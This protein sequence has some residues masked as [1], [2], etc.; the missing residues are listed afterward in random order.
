MNAVA[1]IE[2]PSSTILAAQRAAFAAEGIASGPVRRDRIERLIDLLAINADALVDA[3]SADFGCRSKSQSLFSDILGIM[4]SL[5]SDRGNLAKWM[6]PRRVSA[7]P[8][9]LTGSRA[10][11]EWTPRGVIG[12][13]SPWNFPVGLAFQPLSQAFAAG[14]RAMIKVSEFTPATGTLMKSLVARH[15]DPTEAAIITGG[16][17]V[18]A[19]F[20]KLPFD[21]IL[22]TGATDIARHVQRACADNLTPCILEL[23]G[24]SPVVIAPGANLDKAAAR[25]AVGKILNAGQICLSP[26]YVFVPRGV[27]NQFADAMLKAYSAMYTS[28]R[29]NDNYTSIIST[30]H[31]QRLRAHVA[32]ARAKGARVIEF[33][34]ANE[35]F[36]AQQH[37]KMPLT[38]IQ[39]AT[40]EMSVMQEEIFGPL[41]P[42]LTYRNI[43]E[44]ISF[45]NAHPRALATYWF[46]PEDG[47]CRHY[48]DRTRTG[49]VSINDILVHVANEHLPFGGIGDSGMGHYHGRAGFEAMSHPRGI[50]T[51]GWLS[52]TKLMSPP[53]GGRFHK[54]LAW[55]LRREKAAAEKRVMQREI[56]GVKS[57]GQR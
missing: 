5:K 33:N 47:L 9:A 13:I 51:S 40:A 43:D 31:L 17:E 34:P 8:L 21:L 25:L 55:T 28:L 44:V 37:H 27:E 49:G 29:D 50:A 22:F 38:L 57:L 6:R 11:I 42:I 56:K 14:N 41:L 45:V 32:D 4:P 48:L 19:A 35:D 16:P 36:A 2:S 7:G 1:N 15:F 18:G 52:P 23:G 20:T 12:I 39:N 53:Y 3:L 26:D 54:L 30:R 46:G 24:K 10:R